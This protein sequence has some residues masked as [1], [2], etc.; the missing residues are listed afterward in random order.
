VRGRK[1]ARRVG[2]GDGLREGRDVHLAR[3]ARRRRSRGSFGSGR[4]CRRCL[5][6]GH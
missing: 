4:G 1:V 2:S 6:R 3:V 5:I